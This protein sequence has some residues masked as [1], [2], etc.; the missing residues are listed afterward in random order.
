MY[1]ITI[2]DVMQ[3]TL[4]N[5]YLSIVIGPFICSLYREGENTCHFEIICPSGEVHGLIKGA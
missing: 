1:I 5:I 2:S 4:V 3:N